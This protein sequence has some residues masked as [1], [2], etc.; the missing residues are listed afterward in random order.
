ML[1]PGAADTSSTSVASTARTSWPAAP[2]T[3]HRSSGWTGSVPMMLDHCLETARGSYVMPG[4]VDRQD[5][6]S[7]GNVLR[8]LRIAG[9]ARPW[10]RVKSAGW[11]LAS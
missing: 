10:K 6:R 4:S 9:T 1:R 5:G 8:S 11:R 3:M 7:H 2:P